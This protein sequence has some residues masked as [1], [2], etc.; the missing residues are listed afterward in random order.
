MEIKKKYKKTYGCRYSEFELEASQV[1]KRNR[2]V[3]I[4]RN[5]KHYDYGRKT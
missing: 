5:F 1:S 2:K 4:K 3:K